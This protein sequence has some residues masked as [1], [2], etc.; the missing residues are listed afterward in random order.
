MQEITWTKHRSRNRQQ[1]FLRRLR[2]SNE[3]QKDN[4]HNKKRNWTKSIQS[5]VTKLA[6]LCHEFANSEKHILLANPQRP[7]SWTAQYL[8]CFC[9]CIFGHCSICGWDFAV[10][11][12]L[13]LL[14][15][16][17][18]FFSCYKRCDSSPV[19]TPSHWANTNTEPWSVNLISKWLQTKTIQRKTILLIVWVLLKFQYTIWLNTFKKIYEKKLFAWPTNWVDS[20]SRLRWLE[21]LTCWDNASHRWSEMRRTCFTLVFHYYALSVFAPLQFT[22]LHLLW[23]IANFL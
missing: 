10:F 6:I 8:L 23:S 11:M 5:N 21:S 22:A 18:A 14:T 12:S 13:T 17:C 3:F 2:N 19:D 7:E 4:I 1:N 15:L 20:S 9:C 16:H